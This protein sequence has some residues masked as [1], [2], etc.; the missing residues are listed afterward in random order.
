MLGLTSG[1]QYAFRAAGIG[2][3]GTALVYSDVITRY[4]G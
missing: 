2:P 3:R 1:K 4:V